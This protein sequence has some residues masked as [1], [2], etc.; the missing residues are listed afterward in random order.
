MLLSKVFELFW[1]IFILCQFYEMT[2]NSVDPDDCNSDFFGFN[3]GDIT[4]EN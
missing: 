1:I 4:I 2:A 3:P